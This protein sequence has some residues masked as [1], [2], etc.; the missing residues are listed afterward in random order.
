MNLDTAEITIEEIKVYLSNK[1]KT[2]VLD[3]FFSK[4]YLK[5][6]K[7]CNYVNYKYAEK[8]ILED[9]NY[10]NYDTSSEEEFPIIEDAKEKPS[11]YDYDNT[12]KVC[13]SNPKDDVLW[14]RWFKCHLQKILKFKDCIYSGAYKK[15]FLTTKYK[16]LNIIDLV[17]LITPEKDLYLVFYTET[18]KGNVNIP[19]K[20]NCI[21]TKKETVDLFKTMEML[22]EKYEKNNVCLN[23]LFTFYLYQISK[24]AENQPEDDFIYLNYDPD[25]CNS[26]CDTDCEINHLTSRGHRYYQKTNFIT[27]KNC[28]PR[29]RDY[30]SQMGMYS[31][32]IR[33]NTYLRST[34]DIRYLYEDLIKKYE[35]CL[36]KDE[37]I[38]LI[39]EEGICD[40][41]DSIELITNFITV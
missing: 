34:S 40:S 20:L 21:I 31:R 27:T 41:K 7:I 6:L 25:I 38:L 24:S 23:H 4:E 8:E 17:T 15:Y 32:T 10:E 28:E 14:D 35:E 26:E 39:L 37:N 9:D 5:V 1:K 13:D 19:I 3:K 22:Y 36:D 2:N 16:G 29:H 18:T 11:I 12:L 33:E 30:H